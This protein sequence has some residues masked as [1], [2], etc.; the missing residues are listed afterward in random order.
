MNLL[1]NYITQKK[2]TQKEIAEITGITECTISNA[3]NNTRS[4]LPILL[5]VVKAMHETE[6]NVS[7]I[8]GGLKITVKILV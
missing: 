7:G 6:V 1:K 8:E 3:V 4:S 5:K 2:I